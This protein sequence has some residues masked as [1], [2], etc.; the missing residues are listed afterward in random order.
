MVMGSRRVFLSHTAELARFPEGRSFVA[1][2]KDAVMRAG[3]AVADMEYFTARQDSPAR[4]CREV[5]RGCDVYVGVIGLR[6][7]SPVRDQ[8]DVSYTELEFS[9]ATDAM[10]PRL[11]FLLDEDA[12]PPV[13]AG[14]LIDSEAGFQA[15]QAAFRQRLRDA[16]VTVRAVASPEQLE[17]LLLQ[18]LLESRQAL[19]GPGRSAAS[20]QHPRPGATGRPVRLAPRP[21]FLAGRDELL[22]DL[23]ARLSTS[24]GLRT[25]V[26][27]GLGGSGKTSIAI[28]YAQRHLDSF[29][30]AWQLPAEEP[31]ALAAGFADLAAQLGARSTPDAGS[32]VTQ[33]H[34]MLA[35][36][37]GEWLLIF[38]NAP[39]LAQVQDALPPA[40]NGRVLIT[41]QDPHWP[42]GQA[43]EVPVLASDV[44]AA[45]LQERTG[46]AERDAARELAAELGGLPLALEQAAAYMLTA[47]RSISGY[48]ALF[49]QRRRDL[50]Q[51][52]EPI[53]YGKQV[54]TTWALA[55]E[56]LR[57]ASPQPAGL[58]RLL[59]CC[60]A[61][62]IPLRLLLR[63]RP[64]LTGA[65]PAELAPLL[66]D[67][68]AGDDALAA[69]RRFS[70]VSKPQD[71]MVSV[72]RLV[73][74]AT[75]DQLPGTEAEAWRQAARLLIAAAL[76]DDSADPANWP[77]YAALLPHAEATLRPEDASMGRIADFF[78]RTG[79]YADGRAHC[80]KILSARERL[81][82]PDHLATLDARDELAFLTAVSGDDPAGAVEQFRSLVRDRERLQGPEHPD[83]LLTRYGLARWTRN[84]GD[85]AEARRQHAALLPLL[86]RVLG[87]EHRYTLN[88]RVN[89]AGW[90]GTDG[91]PA[92]ARDE[93]AAILQIRERTSG[94]EHT[95]TLETRGH[96]AHW[97]GEAGDPV[98][99][100][101]QFGALVQVSSRV[102]GPEHPT[103]L[104]HRVRLARWTGEAGNPEAARNQLAMLVQVSSRVLGPEHPTTLLYRVRLA[105]WTGEA[106]N[107][108]AAGN[109][110][111]TLAQ[112]SRRVLGPDHPR[113][114]AIRAD[115]NRWSNAH[116][117]EE[118]GRGG[119]NG[120]PSSSPS[121]GQSI[122]PPTEA[123]A[124]PLS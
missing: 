88:T 39:G 94:P 107:P 120:L 96:L 34:A 61:D 75:L 11:V 4:Y 62:R 69:L 35:D 92:A 13:L 20:R 106:G 123:W 63:P 17:L 111:A 43:V 65:L 91:N 78:S 8:P 85:D 18:A 100:R 70:L 53:G 116:Q 40:G 115:L 41:S 99:A 113:T 15:R 6:Y 36:H 54:A 105:R 119:E 71:G 14:D 101:D 50:L 104:L 16:G 2:A 42:A 9:V 84:A 122:E 31:T 1:A 77:A 23:H 110:L 90:L 27:C 12:V 66:D 24:A 38:D 55:F 21:A 60:A 97:I 109:Q 80:S 87:P 67:P 86:E 72:H 3:D 56:R 58:L 29:A 37:P 93:C 10:L 26:L 82:G 103:T 108:E 7:G 46:N 57:Q 117:H 83:T 74:A 118:H 44:A 30:V 32:S 76:P 64:A 124:P 112:V 89:L 98:T 25:A 95:A 59:A 5:V 102:L 52:G 51:R 28:E 47:G 114:V 19:S 79:N 73:Q 48:L 68:L 49:R 81:L 45:F 121:G 33:V 22:A